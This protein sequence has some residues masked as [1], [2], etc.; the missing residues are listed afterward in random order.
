MKKLMVALVLAIGLVAIT[1]SSASAG[2]GLKGFIEAVLG[3]SGDLK[4]IESE[5][6]QWQVSS[7]TRFVGAY[8]YY[9]IVAE[10]DNGLK[11]TRIPL[12]HKESVSFDGKEYILADKDLGGS[13]CSFRVFEVGEDYQ[14]TELTKDSVTTGAY[15]G[16]K[17]IGGVMYVVATTM[18]GG[19]SSVS[20]FN[21]KGEKLV[22]QTGFPTYTEDSSVVKFTSNWVG[23]WSFDLET[24]EKKQM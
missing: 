15:T 24:G 16:F 11:W 17:E 3:T 2:D 18:S 4:K 9:T 20:I 5:K 10:T 14:V 21:L 19:P 23:D 7:G 8:E 12:P 22:S 1:F 6:F 13:H